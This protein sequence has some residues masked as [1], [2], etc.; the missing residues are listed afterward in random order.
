[1]TAKDITLFLRFQ[2]MQLKER[3]KG[4]KTSSSKHVKHILNDAETCG[5]LY[6]DKLSVEILI[7]K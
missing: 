3:T 4:V 6:Q 1:M 5:I 2:F 7:L